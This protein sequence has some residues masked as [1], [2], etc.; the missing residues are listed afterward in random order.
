MCRCAEIF[1][2]QD[3]VTFLAL[4]SF[5]DV[6]DRIYDSS[7]FYFIFFF[8]V[9]KGNSR[10]PVHSLLTHEQYKNTIT[11]RLAGSGSLVSLAVPGYRWHRLPFGKSRW[12]PA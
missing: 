11:K 1:G 10:F 5:P 9:L 8:F 7:H 2:V 3:S 12:A 4:A 6:F